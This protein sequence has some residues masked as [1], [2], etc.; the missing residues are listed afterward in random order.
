MPTTIDPEL[1]EKYRPLEIDGLPKYARLRETLR[2]AINDGHWP[3]GARLPTEADLARGTPF[4]LGTVQKA[5]KDLVTEGIVHRRQGHG[6]FVAERLHQMDAPWHCRFLGDS[7]GGFLPVFPR[8]VLRR[9]YAEAGPWT[10]IFDR[11]GTGVLQ[12]DRI[13][14][15]GEA[16]EVYSRYFT[17]RRRFSGLLDKTDGELESTNFKVLLRREHNI[18]IS[19]VNQTLRVATFPAFVN[20]ALRRKTGTIGC[21][22][23][24]VAGTGRKNPIYYQEIYIPPDGPRLYISDSASSPVRSSPSSA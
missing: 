4:S 24:I 14:R 20:K 9:P 15:I 10:D 22:L 6:T 12:I 11:D 21:V 5:L 19:F 16:F 23:E 8:A 17:D 7:E 13:I 3:S 2:A 1:F 18:R